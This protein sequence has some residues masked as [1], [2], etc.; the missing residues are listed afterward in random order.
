MN[1][2]RKSSKED[3][4]LDF[5]KNATKTEPT[6]GDVCLFASMQIG[7]L[8]KEKKKKTL[9]NAAVRAA[10][11]AGWLTLHHLDCATEIKLRRGRLLLKMRPPRSP[12]PLA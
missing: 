6:K 7:T 5:D 1:H 2:K 9:L 4:Q 3:R 8:K 11:S 10:S 12:S